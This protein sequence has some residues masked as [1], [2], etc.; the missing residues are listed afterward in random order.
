MTSSLL[1]NHD[2]SVLVVID[3]QE[4]LC[5]VMPDKIL[6]KVSENTELLIQAASLLEIPVLL[7]EQ[8]PKGLGY[9][10]ANI[11]SCLPATAQTIEKTCFS[12]AGDQ[13]FIEALKH[14]NKKHVILAGMEAHICVVQTALELQQQNYQVFIAADA[15]CS[16]KKS[17]F[18][19]ALLRMQQANCFI[20]NAESICFEWLRDATHSQF[21]AIAKL[22]K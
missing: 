15:V 4:R 3:I 10:L 9:T 6:K 5:S 16:R 2:D 14:L 12:C 8:Y 19:N 22:I 20:S 7:S 13:S 18:R 11:T 17:H 1:C 21:K